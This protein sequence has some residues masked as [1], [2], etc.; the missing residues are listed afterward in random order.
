MASGGGEEFLD[1]RWGLAAKIS[2]R[3]SRYHGGCDG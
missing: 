3:P 1:I 2:P